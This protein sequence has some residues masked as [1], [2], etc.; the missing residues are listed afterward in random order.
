MAWSETRSRERV[1]S[2]IANI[3]DINVSDLARGIDDLETVLSETECRNIV[4][5]HIYADVSNFAALAADKTMSTDGYKRLIRSLHL[6]QREVT[7]IAENLF[8]AY[9]VHFQGSRAHVLAYRPVNDRDSSATNAA[10]LMLVVD[11]FIKSVFNMEF[12]EYLDWRIAGGADVGEA[13]G[14]R[15]GKRGDR[16]LLFIGDAANQAA[17]I[18]R[19]TASLV[20]TPYL[21]SLLPDDLRACCTKLA[22]GNFKLSA[23]QAT[24]DTLCD[25]YGI[26]WDRQKST[27]RISTDRT[28]L[29][30]TEIEYS[31]ANELI[32]LSRL[33][34]T[35]SK[36]VHGASIFADIAG[37]T[38]FVASATTDEEKAKVLKVFHVI[39]KESAKV[40]EDDNTGIRVQYQG[41]RVQA[42]FHMPKNDAK[43]CNA[44]VEAAI[45]L[46]S[47]LEQVIKKVMPEAEPLTLAIG[48]DVG[49]TL[50]TRLGTRGD[51]DNVCLGVAVE[52]AAR[53]EELSLG[54]EIAISSRVYDALEVS[55]QRHF[56]F[57]ERRE[58]YVACGLTWEV[59]DLSEAA[60]IYD[61]DGS[62]A[63]K[64]VA[65]AAGIGAAIA[66]VAIA[67]KR[68]S[69]EANPQVKPARSYDPQP[70]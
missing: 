53:L 62:V 55:L 49:T 25:S 27:D 64:S 39:R 44:A 31:E 65:V 28:A 11:D 70:V 52:N 12:S 8:G 19:G 34:P 33:G 50:V 10:L 29:P 18:M 23:A 43:I 17:K 45:G 9:R 56:Q 14:T 54:S 5:A 2:H 6:Y 41:D 30:L 13:I 47:S 68:A 20:A 59:I 40:I 32:E 67:V 1:E 38:A 58:C 36:R 21:Y 22:D 26:S 3:G 7:Y 37:F 48:I 46:Q 61:D 60:S 63:L 42:L 69:A 51:R 16:E 15:N 57:D 35:N 4:G 24:V 66:G